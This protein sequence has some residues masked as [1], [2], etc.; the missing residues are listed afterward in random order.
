MTKRK[1]A[2]LF[3]VVLGALAITLL[4]S[5]SFVIARGS[6]SA[7]RIYTPS[8]AMK[9]ASLAAVS[10][11][12]AVSLAMTQLHSSLR[13]LLRGAGIAALA[14]ATHVVS[15]NFK[16]G[17]LEEHWLLVRFDRVS[18]NVAEGLTEDW[19]VHEQPSGVVLSNRATG[20]RRTIFCGI[21]PWRVDLRPSLMSSN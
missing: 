13:W 3:L 21:P 16:R 5:N 17:V 2:A 9:L 1:A 6:D 10:V 11:A 14:L 15:F 19:T 12:W 4:S 7:V 8:L 20:E 18:F